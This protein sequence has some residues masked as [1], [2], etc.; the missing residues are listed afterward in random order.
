M[1]GALDYVRGANWALGDRF[2]YSSCY[3]TRPLDQSLADFR[4]LP[5]R[6]DVQ[7]KMLGANAV[8]LLGL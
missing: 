6:P 5:L 8:R 4:A 7:E 2:L 3:P 1:P